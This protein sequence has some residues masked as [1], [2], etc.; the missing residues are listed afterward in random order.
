MN[1]RRI[2]IN[3]AL[4]GIICVACFAAALGLWLKGVDETGEL[5]FAGF[6]RVGLLM[7]AFWLALPTQN[8]DAAWANV[9]PATF[10]GLLLAVILMPRYP[11]YIIPA[12]VLLVILGFVLRPKRRAGAR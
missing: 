12:L 3:R 2:P 6:I 5:W 1:E 10:V 7:A 8:R 11:R 9:S 4:V